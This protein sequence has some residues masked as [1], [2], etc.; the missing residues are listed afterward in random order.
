AT[1][2]VSGVDD[3]ATARQNVE[4]AAAGRAARRS[5]Y[6]TAPGGSVPLDIRLLTGLLELANDSTFTVS[7]LVGGSHNSNSRHY[8]GV[9]ADIS[10]INGRRVS[11]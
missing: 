8:A 6:G 5:A 4:D 7:E 1:A 11:A 10:V 2:H 9:A 3:Q